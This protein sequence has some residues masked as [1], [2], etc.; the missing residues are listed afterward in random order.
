MRSGNKR[1]LYLKAFKGTIIDNTVP[2][3]FSIMKP[4]VTLS[5]VISQDQGQLYLNLYVPKQ[6]TN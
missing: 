5:L 6:N 2:V 1:I 3:N 4:V